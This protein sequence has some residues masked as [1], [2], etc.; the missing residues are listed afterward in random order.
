MVAQERSYLW[1]IANGIGRFQIHFYGPYAKHNR[2]W[3]WAQIPFQLHS[4]YL[5]TVAK[6]VQLQKSVSIS[7]KTPDPGSAVSLMDII[8]SLLFSG[9]K[10]LLPLCM[11]GRPSAQSISILFIP[12]YTFLEIIEQ[13]Y[14]TLGTSHL[15]WNFALLF[16]WTAIYIVFLHAWE[17]CYQKD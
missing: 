5:I 7:P 2:E 12:A 6:Q 4:F 14:Y 1:D 11:G 17:K 13:S 16:P 15:S 9:N 8:T 10:Q 3:I